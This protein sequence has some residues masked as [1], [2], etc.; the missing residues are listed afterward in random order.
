MTS[1]PEGFLKAHLR[2]FINL[3]VSVASSGGYF[4]Y[5]TVY[6]KEVIPIKKL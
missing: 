4:I 2:E 1:V 6:P 3:K 5:N